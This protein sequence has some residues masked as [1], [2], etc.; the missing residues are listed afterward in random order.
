MIMWSAGLT[1]LSVDDWQPNEDSRCCRDAVSETAAQQF[2][3]GIDAV[4]T[5][6]IQARQANKDRRVIAASDHDRTSSYRDTDHSGCRIQL[7]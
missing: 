7:Y 3:A 6:R 4:C 5:W 2:R 1:E